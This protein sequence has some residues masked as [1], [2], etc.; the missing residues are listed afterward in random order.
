M[1]M[2]TDHSF[3]TLF[4]DLDDTLYP[5]NNGLWDA[6]RARMHKYMHEI[7]GIPR[8]EIQALQSHYYQTYGT[9]MLGLK[10][11]YG[12]DINDYLRFVHDLPLTGFLKPDPSLKQMLDS[13]PQSKWIFTNADADHAKRVMAALDVQRCFEGII[14]VRRMDYSCKPYPQV[15]HRAVQ[16]ANARE[17]ESC[18]LIDDAHRNIKTAMDLGFYTVLVGHVDDKDT[19]HKVIKK[20]LDLPIAFSELWG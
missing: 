18:V 20:L 3:D 19:A 9:T 7:I 15:Y 13:L 6:I 1:S 12:I 11:N 16:I 5:A 10:E 4:I 14:D 2:R 17:P 8:D